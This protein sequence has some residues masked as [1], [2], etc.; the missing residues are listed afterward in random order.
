VSEL[1]KGI[2][3]N[4]TSPNVPDSNLE[5]SNVVE[6]AK[7]IQEREARMKPEPEQEIT[8]MNC[9]VIITFKGKYYPAKSM[10]QWVSTHPEGIKWQKEQE[11][12]QRRKYSAAR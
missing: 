10:Y 9:Q 12:K 1:A 7:K 4:F 3:R 11:Q 8:F 5:N 2:D 6:E